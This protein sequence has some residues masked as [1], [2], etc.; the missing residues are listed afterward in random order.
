V[1]FFYFSE[2]SIA[3]QKNSVNCF[4]AVRIIFSLELPRTNQYNKMQISCMRGTIM[5]TTVLFDL[6]GTLLPMDQEKF[7][8]AY[9][10]RM[11]K[12]LAPHGYDPEQ[13]AKAIWMGTGAMIKNDGSQ[14]NEV[15]FWQV[16]NKAM[17]RDC[18]QDEA[19]FLDYY[20]NEFQLVAEDCGFDSRA[21]EAICEIKKLGYR[22]GLAT[23]PLFPAIAT[24]SRTRWAGLNIEDF[25]L[26]TTY[27]ASRHCKPNPDYYR[28][29]LEILNLI[30]QEC[31]MVGNDAKE[32]T[33]VEALGIPV[34][35]LTDC[36]INSDGR[37]IS[38]YP[39]GGFD[40]LI[41]YIHSL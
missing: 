15:L 3:K 38:K 30:P 16:F 17:D 21:G 36:L 9:L 6:D 1:E 40:E 25:D 4:V 5:I 20:R 34:Y 32:D 35:L 28:D 14:T 23:N 31:V 26:I 2:N 13:L 39:N 27:E 24:Q 41:A 8:K 12:K 7:V 22:V 37:D 19:L 18:Q 11:A 33:A 10:G 29:I